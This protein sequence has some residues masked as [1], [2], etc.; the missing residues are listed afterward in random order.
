LWW[1]NLIVRVASWILPGARRVEW[2][3]EWESKIWHW[4]HFL[5]ESNRLTLR[6][7]QDLMRYC[8][9]A[10]PDALW[11]RFDRAAVLRLLDE[12]PR[13]P[14]FCLLSCLGL[15]ALLLFGHPTA[16]FFDMMAPATHR[17]P[18]HLLNV[19][20]SEDTYWLEPEL[21]RD[22]A[23]RWPRET[24]TIVAAAVYAWRPGM[25]RGPR[26]AEA[27]LSARVASGMFELLGVRPTMGR[28]F[29]D[30]DSSSCQNCV[31]LGDTLWRSQFGREPQVIGRSLVLNGRTVTVIGV[32]P[33]D[34]RFPVRDISIY[35]FFEAPHARLPRFEWPGVLLRVPARAEPRAAKREVER[36]VSRADSLPRDA[37]L[38]ISSLKDLEDAA[39]RSW[40]SLIL[41]ALVPLLA[42]NGAQFARLR[43]TGPRAGIRDKL[44]WYLFFSFKTVLLLIAALMAS[45]ELSHLVVSR[46]SSANPYSLASVAA[47]WFFLLGA[48]LTLAWSVR[49]Q[50]GR[51][52][53]CMKGLGLRVNLASPGRILIDL[54]GD[55][56]VCDEGHG[57]LHIPVMESGSVDSERWT[58]LDESW[59][60]LLGQRETRIELS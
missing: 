29:E 2:R 56:L 13:S 43:T 11:H 25:V 27:V 47:I 42:I 12:V 59:Q 21:L 55:E 14:R 52:R 54:T 5:V 46:S 19:S 17:D 37:R 3:H 6:T 18:A 40:A 36:V 34:F 38:R 9:G 45:L 10:F 48:H 15:L 30:S 57:M 53:V 58:Y 44:R 23:A 31:V 4:C 22:S 32:L 16:F 49:D 26:G 50:L 24:P 35:S 20:L 39:L 8:W 60:V 41:L 7:E 1:S 28:A 51:C 33:R